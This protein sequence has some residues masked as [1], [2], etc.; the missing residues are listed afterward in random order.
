[1]K[2]MVP[3]W[4]CD[5]EGNIDAHSASSSAAPLPDIATAE[6]AGISDGRH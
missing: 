6:D 2:Y 5:G 1:M 3:C 4:N